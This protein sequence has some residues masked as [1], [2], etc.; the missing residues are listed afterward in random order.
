MKSVSTY[1]CVVTEQILLLMAFFFFLKALNH[2]GGWRGCQGSVPPL[3]CKCC[4]ERDLHCFSLRNTQCLSLEQCD[5]SEL[6]KCWSV[7]DLR[8]VYREANVKLFFHLF[9]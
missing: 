8:T 3:E 5:S 7:H 1:G 6:I 9:S 2:F 4:Q